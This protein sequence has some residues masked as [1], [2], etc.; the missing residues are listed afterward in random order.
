MGIIRRVC[1]IFVHLFGL[2]ACP[3][4]PTQTAP[5]RKETKEDCGRR[6]RMQEVLRH[7]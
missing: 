6:R 1:S 3:V 5:R 4:P 2:D 7:E